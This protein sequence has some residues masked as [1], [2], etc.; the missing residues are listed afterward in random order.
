MGWLENFLTG[1]LLAQHLRPASPPFSLTSAAR[2]GRTCSQ[3]MARV[4]LHLHERT[5]RESA[6]RLFWKPFLQSCSLQG[7]GRIPGWGSIIIAGESPLKEQCR[8]L[9]MA[10]QG[11]DRLQEGSSGGWG[12]WKSFFFRLSLFTSFEQVQTSV[13]FPFY[14][15]C[16]FFPLTLFLTTCPKSRTVGG[17]G[18]ERVA[19]H[20]PSFFQPQLEGLVSKK[21]NVSVILFLSRVF[22]S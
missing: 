14:Q 10:E 9:A 19:S 11:F 15:M 4:V 3:G 21:A 5:S 22:P 1:W 6:C 16:P 17:L 13:S 12:H 20:F 18:M 8:P 7:S 2:C